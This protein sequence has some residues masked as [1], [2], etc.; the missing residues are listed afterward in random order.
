MTYFLKPIIEIFHI[1]WIYSQVLITSRYSNF[2]DL[3]NGETD[4][5]TKLDYVF[6][7]LWSGTL[8]VIAGLVGMCAS[9]NS[10]RWR[11]F[12]HKSGLKIVYF[13][14]LLPVS[15]I[16]TAVFYLLAIGGALTTAWISGLIAGHIMDDQETVCNLPSPIMPVQGGPTNSDECTKF[17]LFI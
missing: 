7:G 10:R 11:Y 12:K 17:N 3:D 9:Y 13:T 15:L 5:I 14:Y 1:K 6:A 2:G 4:S 16:C 8:Y